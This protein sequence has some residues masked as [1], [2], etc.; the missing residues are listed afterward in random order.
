MAAVL[1]ETGAGHIFDWDDSEGISEYVDRLWEAFKRGEVMTTDADIEKYSRRMTTK[2]MV[3]VFES[4]T[5]Q[6]LFVAGR[7]LND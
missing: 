1:K 2:K 6:A 3:E 4:A 5:F 7:R